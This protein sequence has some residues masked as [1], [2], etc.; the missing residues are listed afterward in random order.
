MGALPPHNPSN[1]PREK[2]MQSRSGLRILLSFVATLLLS[3][4]AQAL[5]FRAYVAS[6]GSD[7]NPCTLPLPCRLLPA[8]LSAVLDGGEIWMLDS[9]NYN[10]GTVVVAKSVSILA[11]P[12]AIGSVV[13]AGGPAISIAAPDL[14]VALRNLVVV[15]LPGA[16]GTSGVV[17]TGASSLVIEDSVF[18]NLPASGVDAFAGKVWVTNSTF[19]N[20][21]YGVLARG[22]ARADVSGSKFSRHYVSL[23]SHSESATSSSIS[24]TDSV[25]AYSDF[26]I[27]TQSEFAGASTSIHLTRCTVTH[28]NVSALWVR[29]I[30]SS[31]SYISFGYGMV[32]RNAAGYQKNVGGGGE[33][34]F[35]FGNSQFIDNGPSSGA[36][37]TQ[38]LQ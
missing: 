25:F 5:V 17:M 28:A 8:A 23:F 20:S 18:A 35:T 3:T 7:A 16:G 32:A 9:A 22:G 15:P 33:A 10:T 11:V 2:T 30:P 4:S 37:T 13:A 27:A 12:G 6:D 19:R 14:T 29:A 24:A 36:L 38:V 34:I 1:N 31:S 21:Q 26:P